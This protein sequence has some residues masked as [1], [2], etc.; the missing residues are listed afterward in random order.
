MLFANYPMTFHGE[1]RL[2]AI[3]ANRQLAAAGYMRPHGAPDFTFS[4]I[5][6]LRVEG[7]QI[8]EITSFSAALCRSFERAMSFSA[9]PV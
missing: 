3:G 7:G 1:H 4:G 8:A 6:V 5:H 2:V 9:Q